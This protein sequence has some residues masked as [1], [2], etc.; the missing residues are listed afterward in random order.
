MSYI[1][2]QSSRKLPLVTL[3]N[4]PPFPFVR[5]LWPSYKS[6]L[7]QFI[8]VHFAGT[9]IPEKREKKGERE[10]ERERESCETVFR[11]FATLRN[12][13]NDVTIGSALARLHRRRTVNYRVVSTAAATPYFLQKE[14]FRK[15]KKATRTSSVAQCAALFVRINYIRQIPSGFMLHRVRLSLRSS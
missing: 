14:K 8:S 11:L 3:A 15:K 1:R 4:Y 12:G 6:S 2:R 7:I 9:Y 10:R 5:R 13:T